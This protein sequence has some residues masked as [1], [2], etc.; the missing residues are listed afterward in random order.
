MAGS[1]SK[2]LPQR[3]PDLLKEECSWRDSQKWLEEQGYMLRPRYRPEWI[4]SYTEDDDPYDFENGGLLMHPS[5]LDATRIATN[6]LVMLKR[7]LQQVH[8]HE[9]ELT[10]YFSEEPLRSDPRN[11]CTPLL[12]VLDVPDNSDMKIMVFPL[13]RDYNNPR[14]ETIGEALE[15]LRQIF[16][17]LYFMHQYHVVYRSMFIILIG[18]YVILTSF[19]RDCGHLNIMMDPKPL[20]L[21]MYHP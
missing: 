2:L 7:V 9:V 17:G 12:D 15:F 14:F 20:Y 21:N 13:L 18:T 8:P 4:P 3:K 19:Y 1:S 6:E 5:I 11:H 16:E 10:R